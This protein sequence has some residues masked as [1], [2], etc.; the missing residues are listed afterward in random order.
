[1]KVF[2]YILVPELPLIVDLT[3]LLVNF[4]LNAF[5]SGNEESQKTSQMHH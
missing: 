5:K 4:F 3:F 2:M 1:M